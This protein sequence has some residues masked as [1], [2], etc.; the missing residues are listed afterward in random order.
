MPF[1][2]SYLPTEIEKNEIPTSYLIAK[3]TESSKL[4]TIKELLKSG[5]H[6]GFTKFLEQIICI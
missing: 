2:S 6:S 5:A 3:T 4:D 1:F